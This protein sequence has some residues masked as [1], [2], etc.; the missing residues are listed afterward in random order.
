MTGG[1]LDENQIRKIEE[2]LHHYRRL[3]QKKEDILRLIDE[4]GQLSEELKKSR[5]MP[6]GS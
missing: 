1:E 5:F 2:L 3:E 6:V 4:Q